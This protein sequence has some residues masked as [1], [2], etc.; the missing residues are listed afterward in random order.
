MIDLFYLTIDGILEGTLTLDKS[1]LECNGNE[2]TLHIPESFK[3]GAS[4]LHAV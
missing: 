1:V 3:T 4:P 2:G